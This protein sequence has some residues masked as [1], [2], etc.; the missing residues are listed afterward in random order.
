MG[1]V[2]TGGWLVIRWMGLQGGSRAIIIYR[3]RERES[4]G[5]LLLCMYYC[6]ICL[7]LLRLRSGVM[8][9]YL[10]D[11]WEAKNLI[12]TWACMREGMICM[13]VQA[14]SMLEYK[15]GDEDVPGVAKMTCSW[16]RT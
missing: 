7:L 5:P 9:R 10:I 15:V 4:G 16:F 12:D 11:Y 1:V 14:A 13:L 8:I 3:E 2:D 6:C